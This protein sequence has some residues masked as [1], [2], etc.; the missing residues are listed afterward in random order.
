VTLVDVGVAELDEEDEELGGTRTT[1]AE[2][3]IT[4]GETLSEVEV[5]MGTWTTGVLGTLGGEEELGTPQKVI[6]IPALS[7]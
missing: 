5:A 7:T 4:V 2:V 6:V 3:G 1:G